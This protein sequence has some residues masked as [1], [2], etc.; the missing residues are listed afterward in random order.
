MRMRNTILVIIAILLLGGCAAYKELEPEPP[1]SFIPGNYIELKDDDEYFELDEGKKYFIKFPQPTEENIYLVLIINNKLNIESYLTRAFDDGEPP[2][3]K[4][5]DESEDPINLSLYPLDRTVPT[6]YWVIEEVRQDMVLRLEYRYVAGWRYKFETKQAQFVEILRQNTQPR[7][8][9]DSIGI[10]IRPENVNFRHE[11]EKIKSRT[12]LIK[13]VNN[14]LSEIEA[15]FPSDI[16]SSSDASY[17]QYLAFKKNIADEL[18]YQAKFA[19]FLDIFALIGQQGTPAVTIVQRLPD[20]I[21]F[22]QSPSEYPQNVLRVGS[23]LLVPYVPKVTTYVKNQLQQKNDS[24]S[25]QFK[26]DEIEQLYELS[27]TSIDNNFAML[28]SFIDSFNGSVASFQASQ[29]EVANIKKEIGA[30]TSWPG[31]T[32]YTE[33]RVRLSQLRYKLPKTGFTGIEPYGKYR[34]SQ[35]LVDDISSLRREIGE[36]DSKYSRAENLVPQINLMRG[37]D[38]HR[39]IV[40]LLRQNSDLDFLLDQYAALD[41]VSLDQQRSAIIDAMNR[42]AWVDAESRIESLFN[43]TDFLFP[44]K[45]N[46]IKNKFVV[47]AQDTFL[48]RLETNSLRTAR[49]FMEEQLDT[50]T[51]VD[52]LYA[53][54]DLNV[55][56]IPAFRQSGSSQVRS[57]I[58][59]I[60]NSMENFKYNTFPEKAIETLYRNFVQ[61]PNENGVERARAIV[62]HGK[63]YR[64]SDKKIKNVIDE[65]DPN[66]AKWIVQPKKYRKV[67]AL[68]TTTR[69][70]GQNEY[71]LKLNIQIPSDAQFPVFDINLKIPR[72]VARNSAERAWYENMYF[73]RKILKNEGRFTIIAPTAENDYEAQITPLQVNKS[74]DN[75]LE[76]RFKHNAFKVLEISAMAQKPI[77]R[78]N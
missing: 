38:N 52:S 67:Y 43:D 78:K 32:F 34:C 42:G 4:L 36:L 58:D 65:C 54:P 69:I 40:Q 64:G 29:N 33:M 56:H 30:V 47:S 1:V 19:R 45:I 51:I 39:R 11:I 31:N 61:T 10:S 74:G 3:I 17:Q 60:K 16:L 5:K 13:N 9:L 77:I 46:P 66:V 6:F 35:L 37:Q 18:V 59:Q 15:I 23:Q 75:I 27:N 73:N 63:F 22:M 41:Q 55:S 12:A 72:E 71:L 49:R 8:L 14:K 24:K 25:I 26:S 57:R 53:N 70:G 44:A 20:I 7:L 2:V 48:T 68:P 50:Y 62:A 76:I 21:A 28:R